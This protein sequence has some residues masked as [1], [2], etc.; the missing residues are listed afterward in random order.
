VLVLL[1]PRRQ[2]L[3]QQKRLL[4]PCPTI[5]QK[6]KPEKRKKREKNPKKKTVKKNLRKGNEL[7][8][9]DKL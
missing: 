7:K 1:G 2:P 4:G 3:D 6:R 8:K 9:S 5:C